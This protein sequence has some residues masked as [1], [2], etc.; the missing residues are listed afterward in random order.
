MHKCTLS[1]K[2]GWIENTGLSRG[3]HLRKFEAHKNE[4][5]DLLVSKDSKKVVFIVCGSRTAKKIEFA[6]KSS[7]KNAII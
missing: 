4:A 6:P 5:Y 1:N 3:G 7:Q 2:F